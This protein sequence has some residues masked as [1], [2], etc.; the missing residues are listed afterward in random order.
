MSD[1]QPDG[2]PA[3]PVSSNQPPAYVQAQ[4]LAA[5]P[6]QP[7]PYVQQ[8]SMTQAPASHASTPAAYVSAD[9][10]GRPWILAIA[11]GLVAGAVA[12][13]AYAAISYAIEREILIAIMGIGM[14]VGFVVRRVSGR[15]GWIGGVISVA[16]AAVA[17]LAAVAL[18][19]VFT[20]VDS[21]PDGMKVLGDVDYGIAL[22]LYFSDFLSYVFVAAS[23]LFAFLG[24]RKARAKAAPVADPA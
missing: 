2:V 14:V 13:F 22:R 20:A 1:F 18:L 4:P 11:A 12:A 8:Q 6:V 15:E 7:P 24:G 9:E 19:V 17:T 3:P 23:L 5:Q 10:L 21:I 16:I